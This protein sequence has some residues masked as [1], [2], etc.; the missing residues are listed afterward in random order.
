MTHGPSRRTTWLGAALAVFVVQNH[1]GVPGVEHGQLAVHFLE[2]GQHERALRE[3]R[4]AARE[5]PD[6][7]EPRLIAALAQAGLG[8]M[9]QAVAALEEGLRRNPDDPRLY[10]A[11]RAVCTDAGREDLAL[12]ALARLVATDPDRWLL[13]LN[14]GWAHRALGHGAEA[15]G[16]L[17][18]T[19]ARADT[20]MPVAERVLARVELSQIYLD[21][22]R[23]EEAS[24]VLDGAL[25]LAPDDPRLLIGAG[26]CRLRSGDVSGADGAF[27]RALAHSDDVDAAAARI[28]QVCYNAGRRD[29]A[30]AYYEMA[31]AQ[32]RPSPLVLNNL[33][34]TYAEENVHLDRA[35]ELSLTAVKSDADN[36]VFLDTFAEVLFRQGRPAQA[37]AVMRRCLEI[38][39]A[40]GDQYAYLRSQLARFQAGVDSLL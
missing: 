28:A 38:E 7:P 5:A 14:L 26:E 23:V 6:D 39:P 22:A 32:R 27:H 34:W 40:D 19:V 13:H 16:L 10:T 18:A 2:Q 1:C 30:I 35:L 4:R 33:A 37:V 12:Q 21:S 20:T 8:T 24:R 3:A 25:A 29:R 31:A 17:E 11:L 36:V 15:L 9:E